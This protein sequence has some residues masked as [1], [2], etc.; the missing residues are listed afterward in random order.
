MDL[1]FHRYASP[2]LLLDQIIPSGDLS[3]FIS[4]VWK[5]RDEEMQWQYFLS[6]VF[7][8]SFEEFKESLKPQ[9]MT[10]QEI[11]TTIKDSMT[12]IDS[13]IPE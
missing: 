8:K 10:K 13:F 12:M 5:I 2:F 4:T 7:D 3:E 9:G 1:L 11:E 6:K